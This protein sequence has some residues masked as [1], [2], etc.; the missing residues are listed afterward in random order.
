MITMSTFRLSEVAKSFATRTK[1]AD[2][3]QQLVEAVTLAEN[4]PLVVDWA[5]VN[6]ASPSFID[7]FVGRCCDAYG[8]GTTN[9]KITF[10]V[11]DP[12]IIE[13]ITTIMVRRGCHIPHTSNKSA[14]GA[15][16]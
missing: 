16:V 8:S 11:D 4:Q 7:E 15:I 3:F 14:P 10:N 1:G 12:H 13:L 2:V 5:G 9:A 6:A